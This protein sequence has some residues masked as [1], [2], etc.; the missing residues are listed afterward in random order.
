MSEKNTSKIIRPRNKGKRP[1]PGS[2]LQASHPLTPSESP[3][4]QVHVTSPNVSSDHDN[5]HRY[6]F[7][8]STG[9]SYLEPAVAAQPV[10]SGGRRADPTEPASSTGRRLWK[11]W[12]KFALN[13]SKPSTPDLGEQS[14]PSAPPTSHPLMIKCYLHLPSPLP[15]I[16]MISLRHLGRIPH[17][18]IT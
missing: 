17:P 16:L 11:I 14:R 4:S 5:T 18:A 9:P 7:R 12:G 6:Q 8:G 10:P 3:V 2:S 1:T 15:T 13:R